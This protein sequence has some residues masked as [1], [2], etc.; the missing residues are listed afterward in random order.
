M[1][2]AVLNGTTVQGLAAQ[3][4]EEVRAGGFTLGTI[5]N[6]ARIDQTSSEVLYR[7]GQARAARAVANRLGIDKT[8]PVDSVNEEIAGS[9]DVVVLVGSDRRSGEDRAPAGRA[10]SCSRRSWSRRWARSSSPRG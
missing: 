3:V 9:F 8:G 5:G 4:G 7:D 1:T 10:G 2:V 6:A